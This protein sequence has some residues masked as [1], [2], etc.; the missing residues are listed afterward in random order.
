MNSYY[1]SEQWSAAQRDADAIQKAEQI[2]A[3]E[4]AAQKEAAR[5]LAINTEINNLENSINTYEKIASQL[6][7]SQSTL[8][9][10]IQSWQYNHSQAMLSTITSSIVIADVFE[11]DVASV[12]KTEFPD[13][14]AKMN[15]NETSGNQLS[16]QIGNQITSIESQIYASSSKISSLRASL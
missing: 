2:K 9:T 14:V 5:K 13:S 15:A 8:D 6:S 3:A 16:S 4:L 12:L 11:G 7:A 10:Q 1:S